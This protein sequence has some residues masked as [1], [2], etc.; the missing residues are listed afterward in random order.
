MPFGIICNSLKSRISRHRGAVLQW[1]PEVLHLQGKVNHFI[2]RKMNMRKLIPIGLL[3]LILLLAV[4]MGCSSSSSGGSN[5][6]DV[7]YFITGDL[8]T[9]NANLSQDFTQGG[10]LFRQLTWF[11]G[12]YQGS[13]SS[14]IQLTFQKSNNT[15]VL[16]GQAVGAGSCG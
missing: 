15:W 4:M 11:C 3:G 7:Q 5:N 10:T 1:S 13:Q 6:R 16:V 14:Q 2:R 12:N 8:L 9:S